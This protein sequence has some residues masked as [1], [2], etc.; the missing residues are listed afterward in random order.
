MEM[1]G[2]GGQDQETGAEAAAEV[3]AGRGRG[4]PRHRVQ[5]GTMTWMSAE[6]NGK[7]GKSWHCSHLEGLSTR[8]RNERKKEAIFAS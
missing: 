6:Y 4:C 1:G 3:A 8:W 7:V 2:G 5:P